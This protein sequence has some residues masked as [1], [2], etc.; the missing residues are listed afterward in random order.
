MWMAF[1]GREQ[2]VPSLGAQPV[3]VSNS[4]ALSLAY[5]ILHRRA[6]RENAREGGEGDTTAVTFATGWRKSRCW[7][8]N[9]LSRRLC[10]WLLLFP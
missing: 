7:L 6:G 9:P 3:S 8:R 4:R 2:S 5:A 1:V 10:E